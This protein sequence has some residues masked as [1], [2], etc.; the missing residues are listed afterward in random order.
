M[1]LAKATCLTVTK[2]EDFGVSS[3]SK[4]V[5][6]SYRFLPSPSKNADTTLIPLIY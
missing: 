5:H 2:T 3:I 4:K 1:P 6:Q